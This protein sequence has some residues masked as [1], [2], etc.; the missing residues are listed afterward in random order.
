[1]Y[2]RDVCHQTYYWKC[3][4]FNLKELGCY[5]DGQRHKI[6]AA[7]TWAFLAC[8]GLNDA[9]KID[10]ECQSREEL[11]RVTWMP[12]WE[13]EEA[14]ET[15]SKIQQHLLELEASQSEPDPFQPTVGSVLSNF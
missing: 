14:K 10:R 1:M 4:N 6:D 8:A 9:Q 11:M 7:N 5:T 15:W 12:S 13:S 2:I 3:T